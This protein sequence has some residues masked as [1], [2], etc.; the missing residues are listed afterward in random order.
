MAVIDYGAIA[1]ENGKLISTGMFT[2]MKDTVGF[3]DKENPLPGRENESS[4]DGNYFVVVGDEDVI[5]AF[6]KTT[7]VWFTRDYYDP[8]NRDKYVFKEN[9]EFFG[10]SNYIS[11]RRWEMRQ[12]LKYGMVKI[13]V[14]PKNGYYVAKI[15]IYG[16]FPTTRDNIVT[17]Y[18]VYFGY[19]VDYNFYKKTKRVNYYRSP[20]Y[21]IHKLPS[22]IKWKMRPLKHAVARYFRELRARRQEKE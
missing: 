9:R 5:V 1:F 6:Y 20:E 10:S 2:K 22:E 19:G 14:K 13:I 12:C 15:T 17:T 16:N 3:S 8:E 4:I 7:M 21:F 18:K 11:W